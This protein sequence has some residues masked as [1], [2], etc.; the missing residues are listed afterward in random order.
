MADPATPG[1]TNP[2]HKAFATVDRMGVVLTDFRPVHLTAPVSQEKL[3]EI[4]IRF[5]VFVA[6]ANADRE[7]NAL[8][9]SATQGIRAAW[10]KYCI[11]PKHIESRRV[12]VLPDAEAAKEPADIDFAAIPF[13]RTFLER[14]GGADIG[15]RMAIFRTHAGAALD[16]M[17][18]DADPAPD[19]VI[20]VSTTGYLLPSPV[21]ELVSRRGWRHTTVSHCY[22]QGCY[23]A[24]PAVRMAAGS[25]AAARSSVIRKRDRVDIAHTEICSIHVAPECV[26]AEHIICDSLFGDG[27]IRYSACSTEKFRTQGGAG[28]EVVSCADTTIPASLDAMSWRPIANRFEMTLSPEVPRLV[29]THIG[30]FMAAL[31][32]EAGLDL[33]TEKDRIIWV[34]HPGGPA[35]VE[36]VGHCLGL[37][38]D[39]ITGGKDALR[40]GGNTSSA[41]VARIWHRILADATVPKGTPVVSM[42][43]GPGLT[44]TAMI[45]RVV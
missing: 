39:Q 11:S 4:A 32:R 31:L 21:H 35:I 24:F 18:P 23:G 41:T 8:T 33:A 15:E 3:R 14:Q 37:S 6:R 26:D 20:H 2:H 22:H 16:R 28:L 40:E 38:K 30:D 9:E 5:A 1:T 7:G 29:A 45:A 44:A 36:F 25:L 43:F 13:S 42:A 12:S 17:Y 10:L 34:I 19:E 27:F